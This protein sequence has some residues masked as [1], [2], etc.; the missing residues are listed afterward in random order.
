[1]RRIQTYLQNTVYE[2]LK[3]KSQMIGVSIALVPKFRLGNQEGEAP[4]SRNWKLELP[5]PNSQA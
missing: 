2:H 3:H 4:A 1:M 5:Q